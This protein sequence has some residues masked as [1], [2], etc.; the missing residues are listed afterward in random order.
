MRRYLSIFFSGIIIVMLSSCV[1]GS[2]IEVLNQASDEEVANEKLIKIIEFI[3]NEDEE[4]LKSMFSKR[5]LDESGN[6]SENAELLFE[7]LKG[8]MVTWEKDSGPTVYSSNDYGKVVKEVDSYYHVE[9][10][11]ETYFFLIN[12]YP[13]DDSSADNEG[14]NMLLVVRVENELDIFDQEREILFKNGEKISPPGIYL[15][16]K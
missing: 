2:R 11:M 16:I 13:V 8:E 4:G 9:T 12:D 10:D 1:G 6:F 5:A 7:F 3:E 15:P 14:V